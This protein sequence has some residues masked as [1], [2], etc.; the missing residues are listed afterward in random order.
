M[1]RISPIFLAAL[2]MFGAVACGDNGDKASDGG[3]DTLPPALNLTYQQ[4]QEACV[5]TGACGIQRY[6]RLK[7][8][9]AAFYK[10]YAENGMKRIYEYM[11]DCV[12]KAAADFR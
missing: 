9:V 5:I 3:A 11:Y 7:D 1:T 4:L 12:N 6:T 10:I 2:L 8:C